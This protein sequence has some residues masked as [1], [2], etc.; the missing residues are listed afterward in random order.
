M[1]AGEEDEDAGAGFEAGGFGADGFGG[2]FPEGLLA[3][4]GAAFADEGAGGCGARFRRGGGGRR[5]R[6]RCRVEVAFEAGEFEGGG[7]HAEAEGGALGFLEVEEAGEGEVGGEA[8]LVELV[9]EDGGGA[10]EE[11][12]SRRRRWRTPSVRKRILVAGVKRESKRTA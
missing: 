7:H 2:A 10:L 3:G 6:G 8:A 9:E 1:E 11:G 12:S 5:S 4:L